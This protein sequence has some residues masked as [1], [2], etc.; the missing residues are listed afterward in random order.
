MKRER[1]ETMLKAVDS[2]RELLALKTNSAP[3]KHELNA[4]IS[5]LQNKLEQLELQLR[6]AA[7]EG[8]PGNR[9]LL[10]PPRKFSGRLFALKGDV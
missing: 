10:N 4:S 7:E 5:Q 8:G 2:T 3:E 9:R 1:T 6:N